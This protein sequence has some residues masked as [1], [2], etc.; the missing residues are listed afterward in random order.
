MDRERCIKSRREER[1]ANESWYHCDIFVLSVFSRLSKLNIKSLLLSFLHLLDDLAFSIILKASSG[2]FVQSQ[3]LLVRVL[4][5]DILALLAL[6]THVCDC[7][8]DT[9]TV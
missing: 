5:Q 7:A 1:I 8:H 6:E 3:D 4:H 2:D 9:P